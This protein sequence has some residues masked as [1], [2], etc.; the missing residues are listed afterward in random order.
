MIRPPASAF[1]VRYSSHELYLVTGLPGRTRTCTL[2]IRNRV[3]LQS[4]YGK[5]ISCLAP[6]SPVTSRLGTG[7]NRLRPADRPGPPQDHVQRCADPRA[8]E[9]V[10]GTDRLSASR[11][12]AP[13]SNWHCQRNPPPR[14]CL[15]EGPRPWRHCHFR[16][17][18]RVVPNGLFA[19][20]IFP[21][22]VIATWVLV[23]TR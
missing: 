16:C 7:G 18:F 11:V 23:A 4:S 19:R 22:K 17:S 6:V 5:M 20:L 12:L 9:E 8:A 1:Q 13:A 2:S 10:A 3:L 21:L 14:L 15:T